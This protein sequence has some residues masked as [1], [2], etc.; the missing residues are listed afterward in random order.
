[1]KYII[2]LGNPGT[3]YENN[4]H[5]IG[6]LILDFIAKKVKA[7][8][9]RDRKSLVAKKRS[10]SL[11][12]PQTYMNLSGQAVKQFDFTYNQDIII[13]VDDIYL[14][15]G[16]VRIREKGGDGG[17]NGLLSI[18]EELNTNDFSRIRIGVG[19]PDNID[20]KNFVLSDFQEFELEGLK[21]TL[22][23]VYQLINHFVHRD[24]REMLNYYSKNKKSYSESMADFQ[25]RSPKEE[26]K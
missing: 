3:E 23:F 4:R 19:S 22:E 2:G 10:Y 6:F 20:I 17:H 21:K 12:K 8:F 16:E 18:I 14:P 26:N 1:M 5:N 25:N 15:L 7:E 11:V 9:I 24:Y 13:I